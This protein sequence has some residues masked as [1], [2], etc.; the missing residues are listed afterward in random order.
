MVIQRDIFRGT[1]RTTETDRPVRFLPW[2]ELDGL[3]AQKPE[4]KIP[5]NWE[6]LPMLSPSPLFR[7]RVDMLLKLTSSHL[8]QRGSRGC[9]YTAF[10]DSDV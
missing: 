8:S 2:Y 1:S 9:S 5:L 6:T 3:D 4:R 10:F 7:L